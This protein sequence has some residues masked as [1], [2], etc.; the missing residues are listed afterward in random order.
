MVTGSLQTKSG[1][2]YAVLRIPD[3]KGK[4]KQKWI[5]TDIKA[6]GNNKRQANARFREILVEN[7]QQKIVYSADILFLDWIEKWMEQKKNE[8]RL[9]TYEGYES[10]LEAHI[11]PFFRSL[12]L[13]L[14]T[15]TP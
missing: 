4:I 7:E 15:V 9:I 12:K 14:K 8:V 6:N 13:T 3:D 5:S 11:I 1:M 2:Y 10:Y